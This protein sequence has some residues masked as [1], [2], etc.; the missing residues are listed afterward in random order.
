[1]TTFCFGFYI[2]NLTVYLAIMGRRTKANGKYPEHRKRAAL[3]AEPEFVNLLRN[4]FPAW[5]DGTAALF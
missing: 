5:R 2:D 1:M 4:R 3:K